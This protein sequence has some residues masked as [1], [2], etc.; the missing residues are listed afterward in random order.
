MTTLLKR[1]RDEGEKAHKKGCATAKVGSPERDY[2]LER[3][4]TENIRRFSVTL[5]LAKKRHE[6]D[7]NN[8]GEQLNEALERV[9]R[10]ASSDE[11][12]KMKEKL[13]SNCWGLNEPP[14]FD[15]NIRCVEFHFLK[16]AI[17]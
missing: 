1:R 3:R 9:A 15:A 17:C 8:S 12:Q 6:K 14:F 16:I 10:S 13:R 4:L 5:C 11:V 2:R 7:R